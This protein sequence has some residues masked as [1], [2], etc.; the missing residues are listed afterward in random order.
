MR[1][2]PK[3]KRPKAYYL[4]VFS[5]VLLL[6]IVLCWMNFNIIKRLFIDVNARAAYTALLDTKFE[7]NEFFFEDSET[8]RKQLFVRMSPSKYVSFQ[9]ERAK[10][11]K[12]LTLPITRP[13][14]I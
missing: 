8:N 11:T 4:K 9:K 1:F 14:L 7:I 6:G 3:N 10:K 13:R 2:H 12:D 5:P